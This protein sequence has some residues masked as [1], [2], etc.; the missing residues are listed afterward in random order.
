MKNKNIIQIGVLFFL[1]GVILITIS[2]HYTYPIHISKINETY[3]SQ[4]Y[5][6]LWPGI[7]FSL[8]GIFLVGYYSKN[9]FI[10]VV[11]CCLSP[12]LLY[13]TPF[14]YSYISSSDS[15]NVR[16][17]FLV[18]QKLS[19]NPHIESYFN[20]PGYVSYFE[21]PTYFVSNEIL[22]QTV[23]VNEKGVALISLIL[24]G[25]LL[26]LFLYLIFAKLIDQKYSQLSCLLVI[27][28]LVGM[29]SFLNYQWVPQT[30][31]LVYFFLLI[32]IAMYLYSDS[33]A[34]EWKFLT[35][36]IFLCFIFTH[37]IIPA[38]FLLFFGVLTIKNRYLGQVFLL[39]VSLYISVTIIFTV[40]HYEIYIETLKQSIQG[41][42]GEYTTA[43]SKSFKEPEDAVSQL[44]SNINRIRIPLVWGIAAGGT[45]L[46]FLKR[47]IGF[48]LIALGLA[49]GVYLAAGIFYSILGLRTFQVLF[50]PMTVGFTFFIIKWKKLTLFAI[51]VILILAVFGPMRMAYNETQFQTDGEANACNFLAN[52]INTSGV[53]RMAVN[54]VDYG[55]FVNVYAYLIRNTAGRPLTVYKVTSDWHEMSVN[56]STKPSKATTASDSEN[57]PGSVGK[58]MSWDLTKDAQQYV[59]NPGSNFGWEI[60]DEANWG[61]DNVPSPYFYS[62]EHVI[63]EPLFIPHLDVKLANGTEL[64]PFY[65]T[66]DTYITNNSPS[67][68][69]GDH[70]I[71][72]TRNRYGAGSDKWECDILIKFNLSSKI[73]PSTLIGSASL[74]L[75]YYDYGHT[76]PT[77]RRPGE[78]EFLQIFNTSIKKKEYI[79][80]NTNLGKEILNFGITKDQLPNLLKEIMTNNNKIYDCGETFII[81]GDLPEK[82]KL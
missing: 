61:K 12:I 53:P 38:V 74:N 37:P 49:G 44:I 20:F 3:F 82:F 51:F 55:Y 43:V 33:L 1:I 8:I 2:W 14:F 4:F 79:I 36:L 75:F 7:I 25:I 24:Y 56:Y 19:M 71:L 54:Q 58:W 46:L 40:T 21:F 72:T 26:A 65:P 68:I 67:E 73:P 27:I 9:R 39:M 11:S 69:N 32:Y 64:P 78:A 77:I 81:N 60:I 23:G 80:Y 76:F 28:Y 41:F 48:L 34:V 59:D 17:M 6:S 50:I 42:G 13:I 31:A 30:L 18:F 35:M 70:K 5:P 29:F 15:G 57:V 66:D 63:P 45:L 22:N 47:K 16:S 62:K 52:N 10:Q